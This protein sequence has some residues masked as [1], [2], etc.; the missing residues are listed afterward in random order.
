[1]FEHNYV[2]HSSCDFDKSPF[3]TNITYR[4]NHWSTN[5]S[6]ANCHG[7]M[8]LADGTFSN[9]TWYDN[10]IQDVQGTAIW[11]VLNGGH[12][13][14]M[15]LYNNVIFGTSGTSNFATSNG[16]VA[17]INSGSVATGLTFVNNTLINARPDYHSAGL[18]VENSGSTVTWENNLY[19]QCASQQGN[20][21]VNMNVASGSTV[22]RA[23]NSYL[24]TGGVDSTGTGDQ[25][26]T[27][28]AGNPFVNWTN[29][30]F[31]LAAV[32]SDTDGVT[33]LG[34][35]VLGSP[36]NVDL[37]GSPRPGNDGVL[38]RGALEYAG[39]TQV[40]VEPPTGLTA[41]VQ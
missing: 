1:L 23:G 16:V 26:I 6:S 30:N 13:T 34:G 8:W 17:I 15:R 39:G 38:N 29:Y 18:L 25:L 7:Q 19:Y 3:G 40:S 37:L 10:L 27:T 36:Y 2:H 12:G 41:V 28:G 11:S 4:Y 21:C 33:S 22:T 14:N 5:F 32:H 9:V 31:Q 24:N 35:A 20:V